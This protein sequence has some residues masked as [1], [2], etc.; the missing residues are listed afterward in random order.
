MA[1]ESDSLPSR[2]RR[3]HHW[4]GSS[5]TGG[6]V[7][8]TAVRHSHGWVQLCASRCIVFRLQYRCRH[9]Q[10]RHIL[11]EHLQG[12]ELL[13]PAS[14]SYPPAWKR[15]NSFAALLHSIRGLY[16]CFR[17]LDPISGL[18]TSFVTDREL[19][20][21]CPGFCS[22]QSDLNCSAKSCTARMTAHCGRIAHRT[23]ASST[24]AHVSRS[25]L[26]DAALSQAEPRSMQP[27]AQHHW[28]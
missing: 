26:A 1:T 6:V 18:H 20:A 4:R 19:G 10:H 16:D 17:C 14:S 7:P 25:S 15:S 13:L 8:Y 3:H 5:D 23:C 2:H 28:C 24:H 12:A 11:A 21:V 27:G 22:G 9:L